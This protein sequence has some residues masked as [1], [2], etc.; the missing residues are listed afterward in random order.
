MLNKK[1]NNMK[2]EEKVN[3]RIGSL[4][5][6][7]AS[8]LGQEPE[9]PSYH[10][11]KWYPNDYYGNEDKYIDEG[12]YYRDPRHECGFIR[13]SKSCFK[14]KEHSFAVAGFVWDEHEECYEL[15]FIGDRPL[16]LSKDEREIF[17]ELAELGYS[18]LNKREDSV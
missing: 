10:I 6:R 12:D 5:L 17:W 15:H 13:I 8:Y 3:K 18:E 2:K 1:E 4:Q 14:N 11:D 16:G 7:K 9:N